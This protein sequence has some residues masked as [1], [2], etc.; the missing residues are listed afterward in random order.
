MYLEC[1]IR[2][3]GAEHEKYQAEVEEHEYKPGHGSVPPAARPVLACHGTPPYQ[4]NADFA[5][6][7]L[8]N[9]GEMRMD[10]G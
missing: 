9:F 6:T 3:P 8:T 7:L 1:I 5:F 2:S 10:Y 4:H